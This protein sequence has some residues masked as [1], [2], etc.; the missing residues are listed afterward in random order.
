MGV[1][2]RGGPRVRGSLGSRWSMGSWG[3]GGPMGPGDSGVPGLQSVAGYLGL[4]PVFGWDSALREE[5]CFLFFR[6][7]L[8]VLTKISFWHG[9]CTLGYDSMEFKLFPNIS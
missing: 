3:A 7:F 5:V 2:S 8:L 1:I 6:T 4:A 9:V